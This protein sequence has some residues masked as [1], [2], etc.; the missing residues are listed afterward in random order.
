VKLGHIQTGSLAGAA[1]LLN[2]N[3]SVQ[4]LTHIG[5]KP[6]VEEQAKSKFDLYLQY[7]YEP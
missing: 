6:I 2:D 7:R 4:R 1:H 5:Q 3:A